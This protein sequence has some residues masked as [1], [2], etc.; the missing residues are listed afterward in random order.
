M[1]YR[2]TIFSLALVSLLLLMLAN[3]AYAQRKPRVAVLNFTGH[4]EG[5]RITDWAV[6][7]L[8]ES[9]VYTLLERDDEEFARVMKEI[10][11]NQSQF[12]LADLFDKDKKV[13]IGRVQG[14][15][16][17]ILGKVDT[18]KVN[19]P[20]LGRILDR[21][22]IPGGDLASR[23]KW[24]ANVKILF[25]MVNAATTEIM[26]SSTVDGK[27]NGSD[28]MSIMDK[29]IDAEFEKE[30]LNRATLDAVGKFVVKLE[31][32][33][34]GL[35]I[36]DSPPVEGKTVAGGNR[37]PAHPATPAPTTA[38]KD[39]KNTAPP[40][41]PATPAPTV[42]AARTAPEGVVVDVTGSEV[43]IKVETTAEIKPGDRWQIRR[44]SKVIKDPTTGQE[45]DRRYS[46]L[47]EV[48]ITDVL[49][50][51]VVGKYSGAQPAQVGDTAIKAPGK[52]PAGKGGLKPKT[53][54]KKN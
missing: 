12:E 25:R 39:E 44:V 8:G 2:Q 53:P 34:F 20:K 3:L 29:K 30:L 15:E 36:V 13:Q 22:G 50:N 48:V 9:K 32:K 46:P 27:A 49:N 17:L 11:L 51:T 24:D 31:Q 45:L 21:A 5:K 43:A 14:V 42:A 16:I 28:L 40:N 37:Q 19:R 23:G 1:R 7:K 52:A 6:V 54:I 33:A 38:P 10:G 26:D 47:G 4:P 35:Q 41:S 18:Y